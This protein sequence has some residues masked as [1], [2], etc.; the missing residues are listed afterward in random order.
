MS[1]KCQKY[2]HQK[3]VFPA[4][5]S[6]LTCFFVF[7]TCSLPLLPP[8]GYQFCKIF[9]NS[10]FRFFTFLKKNVIFPRKNGRENRYFW[11]TTGKND[12]SKFSTVFSILTR[13]MIFDKNKNRFPG[14][15]LTYKRFRWRHLL[16][17]GLYFLNQS[18]LVKL[19]FQ[20]FW[21]NRGVQ[22][23]WH[24]QKSHQNRSTGRRHGQIDWILYTFATTRCDAWFSSV[25]LRKWTPQTPCRAKK[26]P[27]MSIFDFSL[28]LK[29]KRHFSS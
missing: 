18:K 8:T 11:S 28:F 27:K 4:S 20:Y 25:D 19:K 29:K 12:I 23:K 17:R 9:Q 2:P 26:S 13:K 22:K 21:K 14:S 10:K 16:S 6:L 24:L 3:K 15:I 7:I 5:I 1:K